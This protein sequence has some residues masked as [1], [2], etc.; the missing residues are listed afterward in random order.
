MPFRSVAR[1][2]AALVDSPAQALLGVWWS[3]R[4]R[5]VDGP[6]AV[7]GRRVVHIDV[8]DVQGW[9]EGA[10]VPFASAQVAWLR[11]RALR[12]WRRVDGSRTDTS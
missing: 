12:A 9:I 5:I 7:D 2:A 3:V 11:E 1:N 8:E 4:G 6:K 10:A